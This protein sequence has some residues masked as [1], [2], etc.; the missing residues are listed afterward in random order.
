MAIAPLQ[1]P[2]S[3]INNAVDPS[4]WSTLANLGNVYREAQN[5]Q[6]LADLGKT[7]ASGSTDYRSAAGQT[8]NMGDIGSTLKFIG[9][10]EAQRK[11]ALQLQASQQFGDKLTG[12]F[13][14]ARATSPVAIT[15]DETPP[16]PRAP[17][18]PVAAD[19]PIRTNPNGTIAGNITSPL[20][21]AP[22][23]PGAVPPVGSVP[24]AP[25]VA[26]PAVPPVAPPAT[27]AQRLAPAANVSMAEGPTVAH[28]PMLI[29]ALSNPYLPEAQKEIAKDMLKRAFDSAK[30][31]EKIQ[32][33]Q[34]L[35]DNPD[36]LAIEKDLRKSQSPNVNILPG[37]KKQDEAMGATLGELH[38]NYIKEALA[39]PKNKATLDTA[40]KAM[41]LP[42]FASG[43]AA[44]AIVAAQRALVG[45]GI[46][47]ADKAAPN[48]LFSKLQNKAIMDSGGTASGLGPQI[49][50][51][52]AKIIRDSTF[53]QTNTPE[54][55]RNIIGFQRLL[56]DRK[57]DYVKEMNKYARDHGGRID[58]DVTEHMNN[59]AQSHPLD[60]SKIP[61]FKPAPP[62]PIEAEI[63]RRKAAGKYNP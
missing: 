44:P 8:A 62:D 35:R 25:P 49:S 39:V 20:E 3:N 43:T 12:A 2:Q 28:I 37:E 57:V 46:V 63:A 53:N 24:Q 6:T 32:T 40:E 48:E 30:P 58:I 59:W 14:P 29:S 9:L 21:P 41:T 19:T 47:D 16:P 15:D 33:L 22:I 31:T 27:V 5:R 54:G 45:L 61:S 42:G 51:N 18:V 55:N 17:G 36:L 50:N 23:P 60:F 4:Q 11:E 7:L 34:G 1:I 26:L 56:E 10:A 13:A 38:S 52:D